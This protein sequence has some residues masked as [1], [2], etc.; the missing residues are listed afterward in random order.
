MLDPPRQEKVKWNGEAFEKMN[1][2]KI[3]II[4]NVQ[5]STGPTYLPNSLRWLEW[6]EY[7]STT[8]PT[9]FA[10]LELI[11]LNEVCYLFNKI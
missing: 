10:P 2:L 11:F 7:P 3:L 1:D 4:R 8:L 6:E 5:F 9:D